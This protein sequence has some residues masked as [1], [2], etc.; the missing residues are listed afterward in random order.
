MYDSP[1]ISVYHVPQ[2]T[3]NNEST[4]PT[5]HLVTDLSPLLQI[6]VCLPIPGWELS[7]LVIWRTAIGH[8]TL[9]EWD[10]PYSEN[11]EFLELEC[12]IHYYYLDRQIREYTRMDALRSVHFWEARENG[13][14]SGLNSQLGSIDKT[15]A[16]SIV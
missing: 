10:W 8:K 11:L 12:E 7:Y 9:C 16:L 5:L 2:A 15:P 14:Q 3:C 4:K 6:K 1:T 13:A